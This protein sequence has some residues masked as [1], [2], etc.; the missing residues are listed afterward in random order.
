MVNEAHSKILEG[1]DGAEVSSN[2]SHPIVKLLHLLFFLLSSLY[3]V[4]F[5]KG[6]SDLELGLAW[7]AFWIAIIGRSLNFR[8]DK[9][10]DKLLWTVIFLLIGFSPF[11][12]GLDGFLGPRSFFP[13]LGFVENFISVDDIFPYVFIAG[14]IFCLSKTYFMD[15]AWLASKTSKSAPH[16]GSLMLTIFITYFVAKRFLLTTVGELIRAAN[17]KRRIA[18][19]QTSTIR[20]LKVFVRT[21]GSQLVRRFMQVASITNTQ[22]EERLIRKPDATNPNLKM[23]HFTVEDYISL[24]LLSL[25]SSLIAYSFV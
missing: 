18:R 11:L 23:F 9:I 15:V 8:K 1:V 4:L 22:L 5:R 10:Q 19:K 20:S 25:S 2:I 16:I 14:F 21:L 12:F 3:F 6:L 7:V 13:N 17:L 24:L